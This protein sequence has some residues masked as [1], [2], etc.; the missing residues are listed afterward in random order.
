MI[1]YNRKSFSIL[2]SGAGMS[3]VWAYGRQEVGIPAYILCA[4]ELELVSPLLGGVE[5][6]VSSQRR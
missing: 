6:R 3:G 4:S 5:G 1:W 2:R